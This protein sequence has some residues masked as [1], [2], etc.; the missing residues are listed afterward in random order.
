MIILKIKP[1]SLKSTDKVSAVVMCDRKRNDLRQQDYLRQP[2]D[3]F[4]DK[5]A[6]EECQMTL[7]IW[8][9]GKGAVDI[10][11]LWESFFLDKVLTFWG[12]GTHTI[13]LHVLEIYFL[14]LQVTFPKS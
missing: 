5:K 3:Q 14:S 13:F 1:E 4:A 8:E 12:K 10:K 2:Y 6:C 11:H 7:K 9:T